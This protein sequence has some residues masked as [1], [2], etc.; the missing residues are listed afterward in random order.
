MLMK[1]GLKSE[2]KKKYEELK[3][4]V[5]G[6]REEQERLVEEKKRK[7]EELLNLKSNY[8]SAK[9]ENEACKKVV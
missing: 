2:G 8:K 1:G 9:E 6:Q 5:R 4:K 7:E 3:E